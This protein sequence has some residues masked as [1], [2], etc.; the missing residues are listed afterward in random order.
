MSRPS[1]VSR[2]STWGPR[3]Q[4]VLRIVAAFIFMQSGTMKLFAFPAGVPPNGGTVK[5]VSQAGLGG[6][7]E[8]FGGLLLL[9]GL[10][11]RPAAFVL[12]G[13]MAVAYFQFHFPQG[14][15]PVMNN[16]VPAALYCFLWLF[17]SAAGPG[18]WSVDAW[19]KSRK[20]KRP[21]VL[22]PER[23]PLPAGPG[24]GGRLPS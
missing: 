22:R 10:L 14:F 12:A 20:E 23:R 21:R 7:L 5:L 4:S 11:S 18:P 1:L 16:G 13:E 9:V 3:L 2:W 15:W 24:Y 19:L 8:V 17:F 6:F